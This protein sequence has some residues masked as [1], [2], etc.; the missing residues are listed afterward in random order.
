MTGRSTVPWRFALGQRVRWGASRRADVC[1]IVWRRWHEGTDRAYLEYGMVY[2]VETG[3][4]HPQ[5][6]RAYEEDLTAVE[7]ETDGA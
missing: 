1:R 6:W 2:D 7:E 3:Q 5:V 4:P